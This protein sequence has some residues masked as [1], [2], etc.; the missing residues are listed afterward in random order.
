MGLLGDALEALRDVEARTPLV[1]VRARAWRHEER[2]GAA[3]RAELG[4]AAVPYRGA[5]GA[6]SPAATHALRYWL[7]RPDRYRVERDDADGTAYTVADGTSWWGYRPS[8]GA[9]REDHRSVLAADGAWELTLP[10]TPT[11]L[12]ARVRL[13]LTGETTIAGRRAVLVRATPRQGGRPDPAWAHITGAE[14]HEL[15]IDVERG[16]LLRLESSFGGEPMLWVEIEQIVF[17]EPLDPQLLVFTPPADEPI[18][19]HDDLRPRRE[20]VSLDEAARRAAAAGFPLLAPRRVPADAQPVVTWTHG[21]KR[22]AIEPSA[23]IA[24][25]MADRVGSIRVS[26]NAETV[27]G[28]PR[29][30]DWTEHHVGNR[31]VWARAI[32]GQAQAQTE[33]LGVVAELIGDAV[34]LTTLLEMAASLEPAPTQP[35]GLN[36]AQ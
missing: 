20:R 33:H 22:P 36:D 17:D 3:V 12:L 35:P 28:E 14:R 11:P 6:P 21:H 4:R 25:H 24:Y 8:R 7:A 18:L 34:L 19:T 29:G 1:R 32:G 13:A 16:V 15:A 30:D 9:F 2:L 31:H 10:I 5:A 27:R 23:S 26:I